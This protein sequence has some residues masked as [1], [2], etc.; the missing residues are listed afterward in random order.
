MIM[1]IAYKVPPLQP[2]SI[3]PSGWFYELKTFPMSN[4]LPSLYL[5]VIL[6]LLAGEESKCQ[7]LVGKGARA[8]A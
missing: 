3:I 7:M 6:F 2:R 4:K 8:V 5:H 1:V